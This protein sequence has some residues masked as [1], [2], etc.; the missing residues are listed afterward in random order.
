MAKKH[1]LPGFYEKRKILFGAKTTPERMRQTGKLFMD[2]ERYDDALEFFERAKADD[3]T[4][5]I[6][7]VAMERG[8][9]LLY[10]RAKKVLAERIA[11]QEWSRLAASAEEAGQYAGARVAHLKAGH[12]EDAARLARMMPGPAAA[13]EKPALQATPGEPGP[14]DEGPETAVD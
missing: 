8:N 13:E 10:M 9:V 1:E 14:A 2:A 11:E 12:E 4:R 6:A 7:Q 5:Q 3:L